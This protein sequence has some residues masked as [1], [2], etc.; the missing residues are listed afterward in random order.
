[1]FVYFLSVLVFRKEEKK[2]KYNRFST[3]PKREK[4]G[5]NITH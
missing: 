4:K 3:D 5:S 2:Y 1:M